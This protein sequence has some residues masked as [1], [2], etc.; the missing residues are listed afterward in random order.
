MCVKW[1]AAIFGSFDTSNG[2]KQGGVLPPLLFNV[3][4]DELI[5]L[6]ME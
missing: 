5:L 2:L 1:N 4:L 3:Y 6:L